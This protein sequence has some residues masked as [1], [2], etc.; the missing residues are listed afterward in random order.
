MSTHLETSADNVTDDET[1]GPD[2]LQRQR[3]SHVT[4]RQRNDCGEEQG[5]RAGETIRTIEILRGRDDI[6]V[7]DLYPCLRQRVSAPTT[8]SNCREKLKNLKQ[9]ITESVQSFDSRFRR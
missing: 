7:E 5:L 8:V 9:G 4:I 3:I 6:G 1:D 2:T